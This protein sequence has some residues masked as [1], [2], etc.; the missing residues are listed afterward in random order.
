[1]LHNLVF[2]LTLFVSFCISFLVIFLC[3]FILLLI[4]FFVSFF[5]FLVCRIH[6]YLG[7]GRVY[8][9][10]FFPYLFYYPDPHLIKPRLFLLLDKELLTLL[11]CSLC[12]VIT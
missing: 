8:D 6:D 3:Y 7:W 1:M 11:D 5:F 12:L 10:T 2:S 4:S 9:T